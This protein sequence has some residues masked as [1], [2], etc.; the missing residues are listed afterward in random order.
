MHPTDQISTALLYSLALSITSG[1]LYHRVTTYSVFSSSSSTYPRAKPK[2]QIC[3][4]HDLFYLSIEM[5]QQEITGLDVSVDDIGRVHEQQT[6]ENLI[7]EV[8]DVVVGQVLSRIDHSVQIGLHQ[9]GYYVNIGVACTGFGF[10]QV[11]QPYDVLVL[12][13][14]CIYLMA[15]T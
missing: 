6:S 10:Q 3:K 14:F 5:Y 4:S 12:E 13:K 1:A 15:V 8:L 2:S 9:L 11:N 7:D